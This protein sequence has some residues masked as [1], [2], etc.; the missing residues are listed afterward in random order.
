LDDHYYCQVSAPT[1]SAP[2]KAPNNHVEHFVP[3][4]TVSETSFADDE[5]DEEKMRKLINE[6]G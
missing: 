1:A 6:L 2:A 3:S 5:D 4:E